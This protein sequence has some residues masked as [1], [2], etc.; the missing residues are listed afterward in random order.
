MKA[1]Q[2]YSGAR[3][4]D[5]LD[6]IPRRVTLLLKA[7]YYRSFPQIKGKTVEK[8]SPLVPDSVLLDTTNRALTSRSDA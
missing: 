4:N 5:S 2:I 6:F 3:L 7:E 8:A 1:H